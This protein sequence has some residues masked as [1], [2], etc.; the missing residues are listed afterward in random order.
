MSTSN[1]LLD[2]SN[3][4]IQASVSLKLC[5][6]SHLDASICEPTTERHTILDSR[7]II[8]SIFRSK[9]ATRSNSFVTKFIAILIEV[10]NLQVCN[11]F[12]SLSLDIRSILCTD[13]GKSSRVHRVVYPC[14]HA[15][16]MIATRSLNIYR[17]NLCFTIHDSSIGIAILATTESE[18]HRTINFYN[19]LEVVQSV[20]ITAWSTF[21]SSYTLRQS[22]RHCCDVLEVKFKVLECASHILYELYLA[23]HTLGRSITSDIHTSNSFVEINNNLFRSLSSSG[24]S[25]QVALYRLAIFHSTTANINLKLRSALTIT[26]NELKLTSNS[27]LLE[28]SIA[29]AIK[30]HTMQTKVFAFAIIHIACIIQAVVR[31]C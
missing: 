31:T 9:L 23:E 24:S 20:S 21:E 3:L 12:T 13:D 10:C 29:R 15:T 16:I 7:E 18:L 11:I 30:L 19:H 28:I 17:A 4:C 22:F 8:N 5:S 26:D 6:F 25:N 1:S 2:S 27:S 14:S